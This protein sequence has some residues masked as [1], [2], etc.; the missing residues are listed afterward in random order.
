M[1]GSHARNVYVDNNAVNGN[2]AGAVYTCRYPGAIA[3]GARPYHHGN[4]RQA[5]LD[6]A[7]R[8]LADRGVQALSLRELARDAGVSHAAPRRH[9]PDKQ[10][11]LEALAESGFVRLADELSA[12]AAGA[13]P[14]FHAR[15]LSVA[16]AYVRFATD[17]AALLELMFASKHRPDAAES[18]RAASTQAFAAPLAVVADGQASG[19]VVPGDLDG[20]AQA[21]W[22]TVHGVASMVAAG[23][24]GERLIDDA[25]ALLVDGLRPR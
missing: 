14:E 15:L 25:V 11:L 20:I 16:R 10:A 1:R 18:L 7:E 9:F 2:K 5:L 3:T 4:L 22:A 19:D 12:A 24:A 13:G 8:T 6:R 21:A 17:H 23:M